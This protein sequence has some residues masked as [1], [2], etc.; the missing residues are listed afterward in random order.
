MIIFKVLIK[1]GALLYT[2]NEKHVIH[3]YTSCESWTTLDILDLAFQHYC[4]LQR[5]NHYHHLSWKKTSIAA[6]YMKLLKKLGLF[7][8]GFGYGYGLFN[9][10]L[11]LFIKE[12]LWHW[13][14]FLT[15]E[16]GIGPIILFLTLLQEFYMRIP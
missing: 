1:L 2:Y 12:G 9:L 10:K 8:F 14:S 13:I 5:L 11:G 6:I 4:H 16:N 3:S 15:L 7:G